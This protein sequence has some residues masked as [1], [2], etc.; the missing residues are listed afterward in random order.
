MAEKHENPV[1]ALRTA[2]GWNQTKFATELG[3]AISSIQNYE[4]GRSPSEEAIVKMQNIAAANGLE[5]LGFA[6]TPGNH[7]VT[8]VFERGSV[9]RLP[10]STRG[11]HLVDSLHETLDAIIENGEAETVAAISVVLDLVRRNI[12]EKK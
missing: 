11:K 5:E 1:R 10:K 8:A 2:L 6:L 4:R 7:S 9:P 3:M 12:G